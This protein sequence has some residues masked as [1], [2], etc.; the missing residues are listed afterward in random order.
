MSP[1]TVQFLAKFLTVHQWIYEK[2][3]GRIGRSLGGRPM[4][5]LRTVGARTG[6]PRT[7]ALL[8]IRD[9]DNHVVVGSTGGGPKHP[10]WFHNLRANPDVEI[11]VGR[12]RMLVHGREATD[13]ERPALWEK[14]NAANGGQYDVY[15]SYTERQIPVVVLEPR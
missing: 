9:G 10:G 2:T 4:L 3:D 1:A 8:Y 7:S 15:Q 11:Q 14:A 13:E 6:K 12:E 5:L